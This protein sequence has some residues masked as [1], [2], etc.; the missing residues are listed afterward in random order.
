M[1]YNL[2]TIYEKYKVHWL[3]T[4]DFND[5][6]SSEEK[7]EGRSVNFNKTTKLWNLVKIC[8]LFDLGFK[9][10]K[11]I[12]NNYR[13]RSKGLVMEHLDRYFINDG[14]INQYP[15][16]IVDHFPRTYRDHKPLLIRLNPKFS[17]QTF[18]PF[19]LETMWCAHPQFP[20]L[21]KTAGIIDPLKVLCQFL[22]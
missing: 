5:I 21:V 3:V 12:W 2:N 8:D 10:P 7:W 20:N 19:R 1:W 18:R 11:Y 22:N 14:W 4:S 6:F 16:A 15:N 17:P 13:K 9:G